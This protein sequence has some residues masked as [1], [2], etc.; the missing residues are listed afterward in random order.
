MGL[1]MY[2]SKKNYV[3]AMYDFLKVEGTIDITIGG[4]KLPINFNRVSYIEEE[5]GYWRKANAIHK[6][7]V[8]NV[9]NGND[10][11][12]EYEVSFEQLQDLLAICKVLKSK[13]VLSEDE[14]ENG[15]KYV[16]NYTICNE[17]LPT[18]DGFFF[19]STNYDEWY[20]KDIEYTIKIIESLDGKDEY[21]YHSSW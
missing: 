7:F 21:Y 3:G 18:Q 11:C 20:Y 10:D 6:W 9:Q 8:D 17:L 13:M 4:K 5:V 19:G 2:L 15:N 14:N 16:V 1:D 12:G